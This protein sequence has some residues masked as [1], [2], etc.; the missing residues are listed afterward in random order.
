MRRSFHTVQNTL[1]GMSVESFKISEG[2]ITGRKKQKAQNT[3]LTMSITSN[4]RLG[5]E[6]Q[7]ASSVIR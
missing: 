4:W 2:N 6:A 1:R 7:A 5:R 3:K